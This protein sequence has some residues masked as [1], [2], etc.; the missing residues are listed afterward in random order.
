MIQQH[1]LCIPNLPTRKTGKQSRS[2]SII[3]YLVLTFARS[4]CSLHEPL[5]PWSH[6]VPYSIWHTIV[7]SGSAV[8][9]AAQLVG[10]HDFAHGTTRILH[11]YGLDFFL[12]RKTRMVWFLLF[13]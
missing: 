1:N 10:Y 7:Y 6:C 4:D 5:D 8:R 3:F 11:R 2:C 12:Q 13:E 9:S